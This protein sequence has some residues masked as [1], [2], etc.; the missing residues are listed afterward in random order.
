M[1]LQEQG[2]QVDASLLLLYKTETYI[3]NVIS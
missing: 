2:M 1:K 3:I